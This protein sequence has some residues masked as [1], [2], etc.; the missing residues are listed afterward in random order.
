MQFI[1]RL[2]KLLGVDKELPRGLIQELSGE[3]D[4]RRH[5]VS[6]LVR[7]DVK[8]VS[9]D[10]L[11]RICEAVAKRKSID[12]RTLAAELFAFL[13]DDLWK[14][15]AECEVLQCCLGKRR[16]LYWPG[17]D[18]VMASDSYLQ[19]QILSQISD[20]SLR[21]VAAGAASHHFQPP[22]LLQSPGDREHRSQV[23]LSPDVIEVARQLR[24]SCRERIGT[25]LLAV[26][27][28]KV[29][30][31]VEL[32]FAEW[33][34]AEP[35]VSQDEFQDPAQRSVPLFF[36]YREDDVQPLS[37]C[38]GTHLTKGGPRNE[39]GIYFESEDGEWKHCACDN[40]YRDAAF[41]IY[42]YRPHTKHVELACGGF[43]GEATAALAAYL[44][45]IAAGIERQYVTPDLQIGMYV[46]ELKFRRSK[47]EPDILTRG[48]DLEYELHPIATSA[49]ERRL[50]PA[51]PPLSASN[52]APS[53]AGF[54]RAG[55]S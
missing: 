17:K 11:G 52:S 36:C 3:T 44:K 15:L 48:N 19:G 29:N 45:P 40:E 9:L 46:V 31:L 21:H 30:S 51:S 37:C 53:A 24:V 42:T 47:Y 54:S 6:S 33:F 28:I 38:G 7:G 16:V 27:S 34:G 14:V 10:A 49:I 22:N 20:P 23:Q 41:L 26:G 2:G 12:P 43:S 35:G 18:Y 39:P 8:Y 32:L 4:L 5:C 13:P 50:S 55:E 1:L 25:G